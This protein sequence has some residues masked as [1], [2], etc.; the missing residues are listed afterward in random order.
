LGLLLVFV[1]GYIAAFFP[2][3]QELLERL[4]PDVAADETTC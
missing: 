1:I 2:L 3:A 4:A